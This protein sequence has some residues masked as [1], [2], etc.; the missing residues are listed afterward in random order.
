[1]CELTLSAYKS[2]CKVAGGITDLWVVDKTDRENQSITYSVASGAL[3]ITG[4]GGTAFHWIP[5]ENNATFTQPRTD[6]NTA[7][8]TFVTQTL[9]VTLNGYTAAL[10]ALADQ[11]AKGRVEVLIKFVSG[12]YVMAGIE[13]DG[14]QSN[15]GDAGFTG[16]AKGD[17]QGQTYTLTCESTTSAPVL[18]SFDSFTTAF[19]VTEPS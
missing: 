6:E 16:T 18:A 12:T 2:I 7:G 9:E 17:A 1:M 11:I 10:A 13:Q 4:T 15:G 19:T 3:T 14:L 5:R 8:S